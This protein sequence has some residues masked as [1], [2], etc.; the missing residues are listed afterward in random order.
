M[1]KSKIEI[2]RRR[3]KVA[4]Y[5]VRGVTARQIAEAEK[6]SIRTVQ[7]D[8]QAVRDQVQA[9]IEGDDIMA[10]FRNYC[11]TMDE[12]N[13]ELWK[14]Y[15]DCDTTETLGIALGYLQTIAKN[16]RAK[17]ESGQRLGLVFEAPKQLE[18]FQEIETRI[19]DAIEMEDHETAKRIIGRISEAI[20]R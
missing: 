8:I 5:V 12:V 6:V 10:Y 4:R 1:G 3:H 7:R 20:S 18:V 19:L 17:I 2:E 14:K 11:L 16:E 9:K 13:R 15:A